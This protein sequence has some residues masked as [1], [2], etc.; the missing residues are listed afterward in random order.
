VLVKRSLFKPSHCRSVNQMLRSWFQPDLVRACARIICRGVGRELHR[1]LRVGSAGNPL[2]ALKNEKPAC[3]LDPRCD[4]GINARANNVH[5][6]SRGDNERKPKRWSRVARI[7][8]KRRGSGNGDKGCRPHKCH[9][10]RRT[11]YRRRGR[12]TSTKIVVWVRSK[13]ACLKPPFS[14][15][16]FHSDV[17]TELRA[18]GVQKE[19]PWNVF[20][21]GRLV[22]SLAADGLDLWWRRASQTGS[23]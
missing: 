23:R 19:T 3:G 16:L 4:D 2:G 12:N 7:Q 20:L 1:G 11:P 15:G 10:R 14:W 5:Q 9:A 17:Q 6:Q 13:G 22:Q 8:T 18:E 21:I